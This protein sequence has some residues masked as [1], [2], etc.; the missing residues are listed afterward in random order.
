MILPVVD[1]PFDF[2]KT[3]NFRSIMPLR[4]VGGLFTSQDFAH[5]LVAPTL[6]IPAVITYRSTTTLPVGVNLDRNS[7]MLS[8][9]PNVTGVFRVA[10]TATEMYSGDSLSA[11]EV[12]LV[13]N[14][15]GS[16]TCLNGGTCEESGSSFD[17]LFSCHCPPQWGGPRC[18]TSIETLQDSGLSRGQV[19]GIA[20]GALLAFILIGLGLF[21]FSN[22]HSE[23]R[24]IWYHVFIRCV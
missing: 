23:R 20:I 15:C 9:S 21:I 22:R 8:G 4:A 18:S 14:D 1:S 16:E 7:G 3:R 10:V 24:Q 19:A 12:E 13:I 17:G 5:F 11:G 2:D 6:M